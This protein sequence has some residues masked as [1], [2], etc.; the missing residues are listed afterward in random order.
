[1]PLDAK[2]KTFVSNPPLIILLG[3]REGCET[4]PYWK[5]FEKQQ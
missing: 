4:R 3:Q 1:M 2:T 5:K